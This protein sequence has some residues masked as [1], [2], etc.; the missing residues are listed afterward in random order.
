[1]SVQSISRPTEEVM[2]WPHFGVQTCLYGIPR[3]L[4]AIRLSKEVFDWPGCNYY[5]SVLIYAVVK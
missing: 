3:G 5:K 2:S 4:I 1:M